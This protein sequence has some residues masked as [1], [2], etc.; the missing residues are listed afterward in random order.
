[1]RRMGIIDCHTHIFPDSLAESALRRVSAGCGVSAVLEGTAAGLLRSMDSCGIDAAIV[2]SIAPKPAQF[3]AIL[4]WSTSLASS[5][6]IPFAS[7]HPDDPDLVAHV[8][9]VAAAGLRGIKLHPYYQHYKLDEPRLEPI[10]D[11]AD[12]AGLVVLVHCGFDIAFP[13]DRVGDPARVRAV[14]DNWPGLKII[15]AHLGGWMDYDEVEKWLLGRPITLDTSACFGYVDDARMKRMLLAHP[16]DCIVFGS[17]SPWFGQAETI[18]RLRGL[19]FPADL[20]R[21]MFHD[22]AARLLGI[23]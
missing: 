13:R 15:A 12:K 7:V 14:A 23:G 18:D 19:Q 8:N 9:A 4:S 10:F 21:A 2:A 16:A 6:L 5:R 1:M 3:D 22:N 20:E 17:D 11:T